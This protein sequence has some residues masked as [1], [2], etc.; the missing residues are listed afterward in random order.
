MTTETLP[1]GWEWDDV[2]QPRIF[3]NVDGKIKIAWQSD[4]GSWRGLI[5]D[6]SG[7]NAICG[8][9]KT[10]QAVIKVL[11]KTGELKS[12]DDIEWRHV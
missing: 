4:N 7:T 3:R 6:S 2:V 1:P 12:A 9:Y 8:E 10:A 5:S 11:E